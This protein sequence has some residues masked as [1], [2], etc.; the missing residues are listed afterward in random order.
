MNVERLFLQIYRSCFDSG[1]PVIKRW[2]GSQ[3]DYAEFFQKALVNFY[4]RLLKKESAVEGSTN[5]DDYN[6]TLRKGDGERVV[7]GKPC[8][9]LYGVIKKMFFKERLRNKPPVELKEEITDAE[10]GLPETA[11]EAQRETEDIVKAYILK[12]FNEV[13]QELIYLKW[14][15]G[16][17][18]E[19]ISPILKEKFP[20]SNY[21]PGYLRVMMNRIMNELKSVFNPNGVPSKN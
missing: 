9:Y 20:G 12:N 2:G 8:A 13:E 6:F 11:N 17:S 19:E 4:A 21:T 7:A 5:L 3:D 14:T 1:Y 18:Y 16:L 15:E 10:L